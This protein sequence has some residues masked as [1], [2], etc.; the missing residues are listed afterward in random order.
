MNY[1]IVHYMGRQFS[2][3][4]S[5]GLLGSILRLKMLKFYYLA[6]VIQTA[7]VILSNA[8]CIGY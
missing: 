7:Y 6:T 8:I 3:G 2:Y 5:V 4:N 1:C